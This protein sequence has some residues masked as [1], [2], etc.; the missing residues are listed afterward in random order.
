MLSEYIDFAHPAYISA[1][2]LEDSRTYK[3]KGFFGF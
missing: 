3:P 2:T 1:G